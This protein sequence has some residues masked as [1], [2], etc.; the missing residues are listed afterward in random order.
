MRKMLS[1]LL[2]AALIAGSL[3]GCSSVTTGNG[4][5]SGSDKSAELTTAELTEDGRY[6]EIHVALNAD[7]G[8]L[9]PAKPMGNGKPKYLKSVYESL[10]DYDENNDLVPSLAK[11][12][13]VISDTQWNVS[14]YETI[15]DTDGNHITADDVVYSVNWLVDSGNNIKY[16]VFDHIEK[17]DD[18]TVAY[19][20]K[21]AP[22]MA[23]LEFIFVRT[24]IF[25][26]KAFEE[27]NFATEPVAT[28]PFKI[29][30]FTS[31]SE[32][33]LE[34]NDDYWADNTDED[35]SARLQPLHTATVQKIDF[36][37]ISEASQAIVALQ[38]GTVDVCDYV[39]YSSLDEFEEGGEYSSMYNVDSNM[40]GDYYY[41][42]PNM[43]SSI[44]GD[45]LN[46]RLAMYYAL[47][48]DSIAE[49]MGGDYAP[50]KSLGTDYFQ[51]FNKDWE[52]EETYINTYNL[53]L[54]Q[55]YLDKSDYNGEEIVMV[56]LTN[57][58]CKNAMTMM[59]TLLAQIG[60]NVKIET[61]E[62]SMLNP[63][64]AEQ[65]GWDFVVTR[66]GG[67]TLV[68]S[69][70]TLFNNNVH[71]GYTTN[72]YADDKLQSLYETALADETHDDEHVKECMDYALSLGFVYPFSGMAS[73]VVYTKNITDLYYHEGYITVGSSTYAGQE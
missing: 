66:L 31:G 12:Y 22:S 47:D 42:M 38:M 70:N 23:N 33:V 60:I 73:S 50:L 46:L 58:E 20:W 57:E 30:S 36:D 19:Y 65:T 11:G 67:S 69:W 9:Y 1:G 52:N 43:A 59:Q 13:E 56:G 54:A 21:E 68:A 29:T 41:T 3:T 44:V 6:P 4:D 15:Y 37:I 61:Y 28:G 35:V 10:F 40:S 72:W 26:Q 17:V 7:P 64:I 34:A 18:Y 32:I 53:E 51:D 14:L 62:E 25:S 63:T 71:S 16:D 27:H 8:D 24:F 49:A 2:A 5:S 55:E 39:T 48:N 45:D